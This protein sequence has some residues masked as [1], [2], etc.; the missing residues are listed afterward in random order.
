MTGRVADLGR[1]VA[2]KRRFG[3]RLYLDDSDGF[4]VL[5]PQG[6]GTAAS[7]LVGADIDFLFS[8]FSKALAS[9]G[10]FVAGEKPLVEY[11]RH[12]VPHADLLGRAPAGLRRSRARGPARPCNPTRG[13]S[14]GCGRTS[15]SSGAAWRRSVYWTLGDDDADRPRCSSGRRH[16]RC[17]CAG[18]AFEL[19]LFTTPAVV[20]R[21]CRRARALIRTSVSPAH[22][23]EHLQQAIDAL[24]VLYGRH[25]LPTEYPAPIPFLARGG[26]PRV[27]R[28]SRSRPVGCRG[29]SGP[30]GP[31]GPALRPPNAKRIRDRDV[32]PFISRAHVRDVVEV[33]LRVRLAVVGRWRGP[34]PA[35]L[36][37]SVRDQFDGARDAPIMWA[38]HRLG[39]AD[40]EPPA[41]ARRTPA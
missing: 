40:G 39:G 28:R 7:Q 9:V 14:P 5:G 30:G 20:T 6:R 33:A 13:S 19:G 27:R 37:F 15:S 34:R 21:P 8:T 23:Q 24:A 25:P 17:R 3:F 35:R 1:I 4:G 12:N 26:C 10:G 38:V 41:R 18:R 16:S 31:R 2:L 32:P 11:L 22:T 36:P 29:A